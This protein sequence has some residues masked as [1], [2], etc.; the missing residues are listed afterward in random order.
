MPNSVLYV[1]FH[2]D[3]LSMAQM[4]KQEC[5][6]DASE[7]HQQQQLQQQQQQLT[8]VIM[9]MSQAGQ[10]SAALSMS[11][12]AYQQVLQQQQQQQQLQA[13]QQ[14]QTSVAGGNLAP[15]LQ[16]FQAQSNS[17]GTP[18]SL[19]WVVPPYQMMVLPQGMSQSLFAPNVLALQDNHILVAPMGDG[20]NGQQEEALIQTA[21][22]LVRQVRE[23]EKRP[24]GGSP[25][26]QRSSAAGA[27]ATGDGHA[28]VV[29]GGSMMTIGGGQV[30]GDGGVF[31]AH[32][33]NT[34]LE[35]IVGR[36]RQV[37]MAKPELPK[38]PK[39]PLT[40]YMLFSKAVSSLLS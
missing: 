27:S 4:M 19:P 12:Q 28:S 24:S 26:Q 22:G 35:S 1:D 10:T 18:L 20:S 30:V 14:I 5:D 29:H 8:D 16:F 34:T 33:A 11:A 2:R 23:S 7:S 31:N 21:E 32:L 3:S 37:E 15:Q 17:A 25:S 9:S 13:Q 6:K 39:K 36:Q 38:P 40:P